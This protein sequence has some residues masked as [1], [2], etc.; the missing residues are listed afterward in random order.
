M[1][2]EMRR[3]IR[4]DRILLVVLVVVSLISFSINKYASAKAEEVKLLWAQFQIEVAEAQ[5]KIKSM[6]NVREPSHSV[7][8]SF[9]D[10]VY[11]DGVLVKNYE[12][13]WVKVVD[14]EKNLVEVTTIDSKIKIIFHTSSEHLKKFNV[15]WIA[16]VTFECVKMNDDS[17]DFT[18]PYI[19][20]VGN[21]KVEL[22]EVV[23]N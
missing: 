19:L 1:G 11:N 8:S 10:N 21:K 23:K 16:S 12:D 14:F 17:C 20:Y 2:I 13:S 3:L 4:R 22:V 7:I 15:D 9:H 6:N 5:S 18:K